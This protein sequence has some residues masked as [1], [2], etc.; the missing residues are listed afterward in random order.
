MMNMKTMIVKIKQ[1]QNDKNQNPPQNQMNQSSGQYE[2][3]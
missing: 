3:I 1:I 2:K